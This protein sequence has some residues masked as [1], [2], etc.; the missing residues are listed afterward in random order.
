MCKI[1]TPESQISLYGQ[2]FRIYDKKLMSKKSQ[3]IKQHQEHRSATLK[4][5]G[6]RIEIQLKI[7]HHNFMISRTKFRQLEHSLKLKF[8]FVE[9]KLNIVGNHRYFPAR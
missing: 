5:L 8:Y 4:Y 7:I 9:K 2:E 6:F 3:A 1:L